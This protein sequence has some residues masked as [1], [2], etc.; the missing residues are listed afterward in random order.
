MNY[1]LFFT[2]SAV[3]GAV[4]VTTGMA[5]GRRQ[6]MRRV[7]AWLATEIIRARADS[8]AFGVVAIVEL[9]GIEAVYRKFK[10]DFQRH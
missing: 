3:L 10:S 6:A 8:N 2:V 5:L 7:D 9:P 1:V 4:I